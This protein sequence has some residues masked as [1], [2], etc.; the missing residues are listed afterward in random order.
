MATRAKPSTLVLYGVGAIPP[1]IKGNLLG[2]FLFYYY[3]QV[4]GLSPGLVGL[5]LALALVVDAIS[6]PLLGYLSDHTRSRLGRR[7][8]YIYASLIPSGAFY[9]LL[10]TAHF[11]TS[12]TALF[13]Q[14]LLLIT[15]LRLA[16]TFYEVPRAALGAELSKEYTQRNQL[17]GL[18]S[19]FGWIGGAGIAYVTSAVFLGESYD[20]LEGYHQ[21]AFWGAASLLLAGLVFSLGT[22]R[23]IPELEAPR[24]ERPQGVRA[25]LGEIVQ[26]LNHRSWLMLFLAGVVF[27]VYI[28]L[29]TG[30]GIYFNR[31]FW[32]WKPSDIAIFAIVDLGAALAISIFAG[33]LTRGWDKKR[34][35]VGLF[36]VSIVVGPIVLILR[37]L[38]LWYGTSLLP[39]NGPK[40]GALWWVMLGHSAVLASL[41][42][43]AWILVGSMTA[44]VVEDSQK[45]TGRRSEGLFFAG[46]ALIQKSISGIGFIIKGSILTLVGFSAAETDAE[47]VLAVERLAVVFIALVIALPSLSLWIFSKYQIT[48]QIHEENLLE[49]GY[50]DDS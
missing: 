34:L 16:W 40:F 18:S 33:F 3:N 26:T 23:N 21:L 41:G 8:P 35:A 25:V 44:D 10:L 13:F 42:V 27:S 20:N 39:A 15:G 14:L 7:H 11:G 9:Y 17:H 50:Q 6:D 29:S 5:A 32:D 47:K 36:S 31:F 12:E 24:R 37:M 2:A 49:L 1:S 30:L 46:P 48:Q 22:H 38:D 19:F 28:G 43:L 4:L 45:Q